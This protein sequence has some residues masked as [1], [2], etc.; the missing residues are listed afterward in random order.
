MNQWKGRAR[1][2]SLMLFVLFLWAGLQPGLSLGQKAKADKEAPPAPAPDQE[3][4]EK[5]YKRALAA[6]AGENYSTALWDVGILA[7]VFPAGKNK[8]AAYAIELCNKI[9]EAAPSDLIRAV[10]YYHLGE[11]Y[12]RTSQR[13]KAIEA[14]SE[15]VR[16]APEGRNSNGLLGDLYYRAGNY[17]KAIQY[18]EKKLSI[19][20]SSLERL[21]GDERQWIQRGRDKQD[22]YTYYR[23]GDSYYQLGQFEQAIKALEKSVELN[24]DDSATY[25]LLGYAYYENKNY[26]S[27]K[28]ALLKAIRLAE[29]ALPSHYWAL[30]QAYGKLGKP[31][32]EEKAY[33][34][35]LE[36]D[37]DDAGALF[38][39]GW[40]YDNRGYMVLA[41]DYYYR[42]GILFLKQNNRD[43][44]LRALNN[45]SLIE[46]PLY[47][48]LY[49]RVYPDVPLKEKRK[50]K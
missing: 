31:D 30:A 16:L 9:I 23:L 35:V 33:K 27:T 18:T 8:A 6:I 7:T 37:K 11:A 43:G 26:E 21:S 25:H 3:T 24:P 40:C 13:D 50:K 2:F 32:E 49:S 46:S 20:L 45:L 4:P 19:P 28:V 15:S 17:E 34:K 41:A 44:A 14:A 22:A 48:K 39:L 47:E 36:L 5:F 1:V 10:A 29:Q 12:D 42:A 38:N